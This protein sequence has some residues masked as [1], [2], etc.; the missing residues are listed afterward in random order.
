MSNNEWRFFLSA[1]HYG[2]NWGVNFYK[3]MV[4]NDKT[5]VAIDDHPPA[6]RAALR[7][8]IFNVLITTEEA[9]QVVVEGS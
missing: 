9:A 5:V 8:K 2:A 6:I 3:W 7:G 1:G 4:D